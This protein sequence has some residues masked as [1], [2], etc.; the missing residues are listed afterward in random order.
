MNFVPIMIYFLRN[1][2][3]NI[4]E[5]MDNVR[6]SITQSPLNQIYTNIR[7]KIE[8]AFIELFLYPCKYWFGS[9]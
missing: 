4:Q 7:R 2:D 1:I 8:L 5:G 6:L 3:M 9:E